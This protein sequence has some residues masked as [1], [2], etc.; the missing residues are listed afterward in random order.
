MNVDYKTEGFTIVELIVIIGIIGFMSSIVLSGER[1]G[2]D[3]RKLILEARHLSQDIRKVQNMALSSTT[4]DCGGVNNVVPFGI[5]LDTSLPDRYQ[6]VADC[7][8]SKDYN[9]GDVILETRTL[10]NSKINS[11]DPA[12]PLNIFFVPPLPDTFVNKSNSTTGRI[13]LNGVRIGSLTRSIY[14]TSKG[15][16]SVQ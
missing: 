1:Q 14:V 11:V 12:S 3:Q 13:T 6:L 2:N 10:V 5:I 16:V 7:D 4:Q 15:A 8:S 9:A